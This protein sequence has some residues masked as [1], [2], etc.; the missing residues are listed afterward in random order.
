MAS[1]ITAY[2]KV[3]YRLTTAVLWAALV[4][5]LYYAVTM[6]QSVSCQNE[7]P[8]K[9]TQATFEITTNATTT[10][11]TTTTRQATT[12]ATTT[13]TPNTSSPTRQQLLL[14]TYGRT[15]SSFTSAI[16][17]HDPGVFHIFEPLH[18]VINSVFDTN[19]PEQVKQKAFRIMDAFLQCDFRGFEPSLF[20]D[21][22]FASSSS[23]RSLYNCIKNK[24]LVGTAHVA[25]FLSTWD[26]CRS[27]NLT[28]IKTIRF[29]PEWAEYFL[30]RYP[31]LKILYLVRD[32]RAVVYSQA[33]NFKTFTRR[34]QLAEN[35]NIVCQQAKQD[36]QIFYQLNAKFPGR[37]K[38][39]R[40]EH[41]CLDPVDYARTI[42]KFVGLNF[43]NNTKQ[44]IHQI[45]TSNLT[46][47]IADPYSVV[48]H[49]AIQAM[50]NWRRSADF[51]T[52]KRIDKLCKDVYSLFGYRAVWT[53]QDLFSQQL[54]VKPISNRLF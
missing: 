10:A 32:F 19:I 14:V 48:R 44:Y 34:G 20:E 1:F 51:K 50:N 4:A 35:A 42:Y 13:T 29:R 24:T 47:G 30:T 3:N 43:N 11:T 31:N 41:G 2:R 26:A 22:L 54:L 21:Y 8:K 27:H 40:Y 25:C 9:L 5:T 39:I 37:V 15:G 33:R 6:K 16:I 38:G 36:F 45:T 46:T 12:T 23:T 17:S 7:Q 28:L 18:T 53:E 49:D 52:V